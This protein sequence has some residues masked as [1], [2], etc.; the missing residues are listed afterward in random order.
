MPHKSGPIL[1]G[2][3]GWPSTPS[4]DVIQSAISEDPVVALD[5][6][7]MLRAFVD[8]AE[9]RAVHA[10][11]LAGLSWQKIGEGLGQSKQALWARYAGWD[12]HGGRMEADD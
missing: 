4:P 3:D 5:A 1:V 10:A 11:R 7:R 6:T 2:S 9:L 8:D 12:P